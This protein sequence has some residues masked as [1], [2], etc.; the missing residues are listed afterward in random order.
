ME[1]YE[2][3]KDRLVGGIKAYKPADSD[4]A[5]D[6]RHNRDVFQD[7][8][9]STTAG[10][11]KSLSTTTPNGTAINPSLPIGPVT[12]TSASTTHASTFAT[13]TAGSGA[14]AVGA[15]TSKASGEPD[16]T[17]STALSETAPIGNGIS[18]IKIPAVAARISMMTTSTSSTYATISYAPSVFSSAS[19]STSSAAPRD[20][21]LPA[22]LTVQN[23]C[24][25]LNGRRFTNSVNLL[26]HEH[27]FHD[28]SLA[29][30]Y[31]A[32]CDEIAED[33]RKMTKG[34]G[35]RRA[36]A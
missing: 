12:P 1:V 4:A 20:T 15:M 21:P 25:V 10:I 2:I 7:L 17:E 29:L 8:L 35:N 28:I 5:A 32:W 22:R 30:R 23:A 3:P 19:T 16:P 24:D 33:D 26:V 11:F 36:S 34:M 13:P 9:D 6:K 14:T 31:V 18:K 27:S